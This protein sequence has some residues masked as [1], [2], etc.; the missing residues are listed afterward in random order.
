[1]LDSLGIGA[2]PDAADFGDAG[3]HTLR[4]VSKA[5]AFR[6]DH[7]ISLGLGQIDGIDCL[8][9][10][11]LQAAVARLQERSKGKD[12]TIGH[13]ELVGVISPKAMPT[14]PEGFPSRI[15]EEFEKRTGR[16]WLCNKPYSG[17]DVIRDY[18]EE[19]LKTGKLIVYT[20][21]DSVFQ[22]AA[23]EALVPPQQLYEYCR[24]ARE[25][26]QG[27]HA[28]GRVI[29]RPFEGEHPFVRTANRHDFS[30]VPP[31]TML[32]AMEEKGLDVIGVGKISDIFA[33]SGV[34]ET[35]P[36]KG[37]AHGM[38]VTMELAGRDFHGLCFVNLVDFDM[39]YGHRQDPEGYAKALSE[40]DAWLPGFLEKLGEDDAVLIT[41]DH[42][43]DPADAHTDHTREDV[44][45][46]ICGK[47]IVPYNYGTRRG[48]DHVAATVCRMLEVPFETEGVSLYEG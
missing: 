25:L 27:E 7:L 21:A 35:Y 40:F 1:M 12:T 48:F 41:A 5:S 14:Y 10:K 11:P 22:I 29:A 42:G 17:T 24:T 23:H 20:S 28:V 13:W 6:A 19:H 3:A 43:C 26:L 30:L 4:S 44:P 39:K 36:T 2:A 8:P 9:L 34:T 16:G 32:N 15:M 18:G 47:Q 38:E 45:L 33:G 37:N 31:R 46:L